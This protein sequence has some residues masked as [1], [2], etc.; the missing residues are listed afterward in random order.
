M[1]GQFLVQLAKR[2]GLRVISVSS[3]KT[4]KMLLDLG[5]EHVVARDGKSNEEIVREVKQY[6]GDEVTMG[7]D[8]VGAATSLAT[9]QCLSTTRFA[10]FAPLAWSPKIDVTENVEILNVEMKQFVLNPASSVYSHQLTR[11]VESGEIR[12]PEIEVLGGGLNVVEQGLERLK[13]GDMAGKKL[14][15]D[16]LS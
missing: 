11:L 5:A 2:S 3:A 12:L 8:L 7:V 1:T 14:V 16:M 15:V 6:T 10:R 9:Y 4:A 13:R